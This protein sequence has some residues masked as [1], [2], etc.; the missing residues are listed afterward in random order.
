MIARDAETTLGTCLQSFR[1]YVS[2]IIVGVDELTRDKTAK[3]ARWYGASTFPV[4]VSDWHECPQH[5]RF[6]A[7]D[8]AAARNASFKHLDPDLDFH[9]WVDADDFLEGAAVLPELTRRVPAPVIGLWSPYEYAYLLREDGSRQ[10]N[11]IFHRERILRTKLNGKPVRW[12]WKH[13][14]HEVCTPNPDGPWLMAEH[15]RWV[16]QHQ[17]HKTE[18]SAPRNLK[19]LQIEYEDKPD[20]Q[21]TVFYLGN[22]Y[23]AMSLWEQ[24][25]QW[26]EHYTALKDTNP[27]ELWQSYVY[28]SFAFERL[29]DM[30]NALKAAMGAIEARP[31][32]P[33]PYYRLS[34]IYTVT[35]EYEKSLWWAKEGDTKVD[36]PFFAFKNPMDRVYNKWL[37]VAE[38]LYRLGR[39]KEAREAWEE[40]QKA[41]KD[42]RIQATIQDCLAQETAER[43]AGGF[44]DVAAHLNEDGVLAVY[45]KLP[46]PVKSFGRTRNIAMTILRQRRKALTQPKIIFWCGQ[47]LEPWAPPSL[48]TTGIGGSETAVVEI[49]KRF[50]ADGWLVDVYNTPD[51]MEGVYDGVGYWDPGRLPTGESCDVFV[52]WRD[53]AGHALPVE[54]KQKLLWCHDLNYGLGAAVDMHRWPSVLGVSEWHAGMLRNYYNPDGQVSFVPNGIDLSRFDPAIRKVPFRCVYASSPDRGLLRLLDLWPFIVKNEPQ[55]EL[56]VAYGWQNV[57]KGID[58]GS[59]E[60]LGIKNAVLEKLK[61]TER[62]VWRDRLS[63]TDLAQLYCESYLW[64]YPTQFLEVSCISAME[65]MAGGAVPITTKSGALPE[66]I[67]GAGLMVPSPA[68][69]RGYPGTWLRVAQGAL[70]AADQ[71]LMYAALGRSRAKELTWDASYARW[72]TILAVDIKPEVAPEP[73]TV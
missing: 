48:S 6:L 10:A 35:G 38:A 5:E 39:T 44:V 69:S 20:D 21:R 12:T 58:R 24:A 32:H 64:L 61:T 29:G 31:E 49:A 72:K 13:R 25:I 47:A 19:L 56:H 63:Q 1:E 37:P 22:Q 42:E 41:F 17:Q 15:V 30:T 50:A 68:F 43:M 67:G 53:P 57:D 18:Q 73:V 27:Y 59:T 40:S 65:A 26:Y 7:Q 28:M 14:V 36:A 46:E 51:Y 45:D 71:R 34:Q 66:T 70:A 52:S 54:A 11:T 4:K 60:L 62:V 2:Q 16:H 3:V 9:M 23:F 33:E 8:F 55:A